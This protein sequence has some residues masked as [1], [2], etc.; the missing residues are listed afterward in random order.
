MHLFRQRAATALLAMTAALAVG[1]A[2]TNG[3][4]APAAEPAQNTQTAPTTASAAEPAPAA[5]PAAPAAQPA[6]EP[7]KKQPSPHVNRTTSDYLARPE[8]LGFLQKLSDEK[9][10]P[11][12]WLKEEVAVARY[13][14]LSEKYTTPRPKADR[15][16]TPEKN[17]ILYR[18]NLINDER[19]ERGGDFIARNRE[20][21]A[22]I[23]R[24]TGVDPYVV[25]AIIGIESIY[26]RNMGRFRVLDALMTLSFDYTRRAKYY[27]SELASFLD[28]CYRQGVSPVSVQG[29]FAGAMGLGQFMPASLNAYGR[30]GDGDGMIDITNSEPDGIASVANFLKVHGWIRGEKPLYPV[31]ADE[32]I[33]KATKSGGIKAHTTVGKLLEAGVKPKTEWKLK[34]DEPALLVDLPWVRK[35]DTKG[36]DYWLGTES[37]G[38]ILRYN[39][40]YFYAAAVTM[41]AYELETR[42]KGEAPAE[43]TD[44]E[45]AKVT[46]QAT[47]VKPAAAQAAPE[48]KADA[49]TEAK[50][51][52]AAQPQPEAAPQKAS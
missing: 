3:Q 51:E 45:T 9:D 42:D 13:S 6:A 37:F 41:L 35:D 17:F 25:T 30:D 27:R 10:I 16:K 40:S 33:F 32:A 15:K 28:F 29:S 50:A 23:E 8:V 14:P 11:L 18:R 1:A 38:A 39:R 52:A 26:G 22:R 48:V 12:E 5:H 47:G 19:I 44:A 31:E 4:T 20:V 43:K 21:L 49:K 24:E 34:N 36:V 46:A 2:E 7:A